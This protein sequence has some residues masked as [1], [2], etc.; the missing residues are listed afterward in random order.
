MT[1]YQKKQL[2]NIEDKLPSI[3]ILLKDSNLKKNTKKSMSKSLTNLVENL[4]DFKEKGVDF[5]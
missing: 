4:K 5:V 2:Q 3:L 1:R